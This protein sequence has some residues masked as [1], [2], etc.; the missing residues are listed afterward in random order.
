MVQSVCKRVAYQNFKQVW[1]LVENFRE[2]TR[3]STK[4]ESSQL[5]E[6]QSQLRG[7]GSLT[8]GQKYTRSKHCILF[9]Q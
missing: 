1:K 3:L 9:R 4:I 2:H 8:R 5:V 6:K 7:S